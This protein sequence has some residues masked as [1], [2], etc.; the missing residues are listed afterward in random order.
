M[1]K[2]WQVP[3]NKAP[4]KRGKEEPKQRTQSSM[5]KSETQNGSQRPEEQ[6]MF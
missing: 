5:Q 4:S 2:Q 1:I 3:L 6:V